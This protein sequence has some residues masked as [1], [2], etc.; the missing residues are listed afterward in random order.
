MVRD[1]RKVSSSFFYKLS[2]EVYDDRSTRILKEWTLAPDVVPVPPPEKK[3]WW[4]VPQPGQSFHAQFSGF[5]QFQRICYHWQEC[6]RFIL[7]KLALVPAAAKMTVRLED[8]V[9]DVNV[10]RNVLAFM[11]IKHDNSYSEYL[12][13]PQNVFFPVDFKLTP[14]Q[15]KQ[16]QV[17]GTPMMTELGYQGT[18]LYEVRY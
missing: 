3:Y 18:E 4:N 8:M 15:M 1:G 11:D 9:A 13:T 5:D 6:N 14:P 16:F 17:I 12:N 2:Q 7:E 10:L